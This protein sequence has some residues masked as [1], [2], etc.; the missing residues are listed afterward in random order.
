M[1]LCA[2][3]VATNPPDNQKTGNKWHLYLTC[4]PRDSNGDIP[5][6]LNV[7]LLKRVRISAEA[8]LLSP[9]PAPRRG[10]HAKTDVVLLDYARLN[11]VATK[12]LPI[13]GT[14][15]TRFLDRSFPV[16]D[17]L[18]VL[19]PKWLDW[20]E[21]DESGRGSHN[22]F[23]ILVCAL[24]KYQ[25]LRVTQESWDKLYGRVWTKWPEESLCE[26]ESPDPEDS[27]AGPDWVSPVR[28]A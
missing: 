21:F 6:P 12:L 26:P 27:D 17:V 23:W 25:R 4:I 11:S 5:R 2:Y 22:W 10:F 3:G 16:D 13:G 15:G 28:L 18:A 7:K 9:V 24:G 14:T 20:F 8:D 1:V 19:G